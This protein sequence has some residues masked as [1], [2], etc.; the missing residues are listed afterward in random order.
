V[1]S[2]DAACHIDW[3]DPELMPFLPNWNYLHV[4]RD[5]VP[6]LLERGV[7]QDQIDQ[8]LVANPRRF[9]EQ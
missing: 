6:A 7:T 1:L 2:Q 3:V 8:M 9:F 5:V 4:Q